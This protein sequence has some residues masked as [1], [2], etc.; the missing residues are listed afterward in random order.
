MDSNTL[1]LMVFSI[2]ILLMGMLI[3]L[4]HYFTSEHFLDF[5]M[6]LKERIKKT[7]FN[8]II[9][10][11]LKFHKKNKERRIKRDEFIRRYRI[12]LI[13]ILTNMVILSPLI[14]RW[15]DVID[16]PIGEGYSALL[17]LYFFF[18]MIAFVANSDSNRSGGN[19]HYHYNDVTNRYQRYTDSEW[20]ENFTIHWEKRDNGG[21]SNE[22]IIKKKEE[23]RVLL[24]K[25]K[26]LK[27]KYQL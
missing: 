17:F 12:V 25:N 20:D 21:F 11:F 4:Y 8:I 7:R 3:S 2:S 13:I 23:I 27:K 16:K 19:R 10:L 24:K 15:M 22:E 14:L 1:I 5:I 26:T 9:L 18:I 6:S